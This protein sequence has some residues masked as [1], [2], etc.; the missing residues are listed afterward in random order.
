MLR[1]DIMKGS[2]GLALTALGA[3][4]L[5]AT[6]LGATRALAQETVKIGLILPLTGPFA[7][8]TGRQIENSI[9]AYMA[10]NGDTVAGKKIELI[11]KDDASTADTTKRLAQELVVNDKVHILAGFGLTPLALAAAPVADE[12]K[13]PMIVMAAATS[14]V[15]E[16]SNFIVRTSFPATSPVPALAEWA[17]K[18]NIKKTISMVADFAPGHDIEKGWDEFFVKSGGQVLEKVR[19]PLRNPDFAPFLQRVQDTK[20]DALFV[21]TPAGMGAQFMKQYVER[22]M[23]KSGIK[24]IATGDV[25][26]DEVLNGMG[27]VALGVINSHH[28]SAHHQSPENTKYREAYA[29]QT[30]GGRPNFMGVGGYD[31]IHLIFEAL[32]K[33]GGKTDGAALVEAMKG[34]KWTSPRGPMEIDAATRDVIHNIYI[35]E[36]KRVDGQLYNVEFATFENVKDP[37]K[38]AKK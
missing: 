12:A 21:F 28:Y 8:N 20:P 23:D 1:R 7:S 4:V 16:K 37:V 24:L 15:T 2:M 26:D 19:I 22:G 25:T 9:K 27:D 11:I 31:G 14:M 35:R 10:L 18:N 29:K 33:T 30:N 34:M 6:S 13:I 3:T 5:G 36:V 32:K 38:A 17:S